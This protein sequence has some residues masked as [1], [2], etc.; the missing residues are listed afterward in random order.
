MTWWQWTVVGGIL[1]GAEL[2]GLDAQFFLIFIGL[3]AL[4]VGLAELFG[5]AM[6]LW[7]QVAVF[8][9]F[10]LIFLYGFR[11]TL[12]EK[13]R[14]SAAGYPE[15]LD[16]ESVRMPQD[17]GPGAEARVPFRGTDWTVR[18]TGQTAISGGSRAR[19]VKVDGLT[20][21]VESE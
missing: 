5:I 2:L 14:G 17:L 18:N 20:L 6:P 12:Y 19:I 7:V 10:S 11:R 21:H 3:S 9:A 1:L 16:G 4:L 8:A 13:I 15:P